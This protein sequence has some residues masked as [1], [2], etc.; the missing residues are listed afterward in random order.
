MEKIYYRYNPWWEKGFV[1]EDYSARPDLL[2]VMQGQLKTSAVVLLSGLRRVGKTTL[3]KLLI[4]FLIEKEAVAPQNIFYV[5]L[6]D[7]LLREKSIV[8]I[9]EDYR[10]LHRLSFDEKC[11]LFLDEVTYKDNFAQQLKNLYDSHHVKV[12]ASSSSA[13]LL[14]EQKNFMTGRN[15]L[16]EVLPLTYEEYLNFKKISLKKEDAHLHRAYFEDCMKCGGMPEYVLHEDI[17]YL[18]NL[19]D[20]I[21]YKD[22]A[23]VHGVKEISTLK[24]MFLLLM[25]R[26]G[27]ALSINK[28]AKIIH[29]SPD[30]ARRYLSYFADT[31]LIHLVKRH[32]TTNEKILSPQ[33]IYAADLGIKCLFSESEDT[34]SYFENYVYLQIKHMKPCY[35][36]EN[37]CEIDFYTE[38]G[39]LIEAKYGREMPVKQKKLFEEFAAKDKVVIDGLNDLN[40]FL[41]NVK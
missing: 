34:G 19:V 12:Y 6:D 35:V 27:K 25:E 14:K 31:H 21:L 8:D 7:Y 20:D 22:I 2:Q 30:T 17:E 16:I 41:A 4:R 38:R 28:I 18:K 40:D 9:V 10:T 1:F 24:D 33:K 5:S 32:G 3:F 23:A 11:F 39:T 26:S 36:Y 29:V 37:G 13:S 15:A